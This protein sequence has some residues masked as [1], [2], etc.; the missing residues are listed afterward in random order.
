MASALTTEELHERLRRRVLG[1]EGQGH[2]AYLLQEVQIEGRRADAIS[3][4]LW[5][6]RGIKIEGFELKTNRRDWLSEFEDHTKAE[7]AMG[8]C[9]HFWLVTNPEVLMPGELP[10]KWGLLLSNGKGRHLK[11]EKPAPA[12]RGELE[13]PVSRLLVPTLMRGAGALRDELLATAREEGR[14][15][16]RNSAGYDRKSLEN[17]L[18]GAEQANRDYQA[19]WEKFREMTGLDFYEWLHADAEKMTLIGDLARALREG[20]E[21]MERIA[22]QIRRAEGKASE[23]AGKLNDALAAANEAVYGG[24][25][26]A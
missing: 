26:A 21:G 15:Q 4:G 9:D 18:E 20:P 16:G 10:D 14:E 1:P 3:V 5:P 24:G 11:V 8:V 2:R 22:D 12:L 13:E 7:P 19:A 25:Q 6:S 17:R 23:L